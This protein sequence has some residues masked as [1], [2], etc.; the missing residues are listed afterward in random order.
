M[1]VFMYYSIQAGRKAWTDE[2]DA[3]SGARVPVRNE[4]TRKTAISCE[5]HPDE[6]LL[7]GLL[8]LLEVGH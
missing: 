6:V 7:H 2:A 1:M 3:A 8:A 4:V 5:Q